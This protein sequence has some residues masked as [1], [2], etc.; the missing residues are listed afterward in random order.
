MDTAF[1]G[2]LPLGLPDAEVNRAAE[3]ARRAPVPARAGRVL[4]GTAGWTD[5]SLIKS[6]RFYPHGVS[7]PEGRLRFYATQ[8][9]IVEV[10]ATYYALPS[11]ANAERWVRRTPADFVFNIKAFAA[12]T[13]HPVDLHGLPRDLRESL[14]QPLLRRGRAYPKDLPGDVLFEIW[15]RFRSGIEPLY[16]ARK[17]G[18]VLLQFPPWFTATKAN[19]RTIAV[20]RARLG[21]IPLAVEVRH[22]SWGEPTRL[23]RWIAF[24][25]DHQMSYVSVDGPQGLPNSVPPVAAVA[26]RRLA[27]VRLHGRKWET[28]NAGVSVKEKFDDLYAPEELRPWVDK[29]RKLEANAEVVHAIFNNCI[30]DHA[31][32][33]A[34]DLTAMLAESPAVGS[35][36]AGQGAGG[37]FAFEHV[38]CSEG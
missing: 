21:N 34:K 23:P 14:P 18:C 6:K 12:L 15:K 19:A 11:A 5:P 35:V 3:L 2:E 25:R 17:L 7:T 36:G 37:K 29:V 28:W 13:E 20:C 8:F 30:S 24:L 27:V 10:D 16:E 38:G 31:V 32:L 22:A 4:V 9:P 1:D 33:G 26:D